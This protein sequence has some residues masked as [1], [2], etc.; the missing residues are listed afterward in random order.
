MPC[1]VQRGRGDVHDK[2]RNV[3]GTLHP[4]LKMNPENRPFKTESEVG[5]VVKS[6]LHDLRQ[7]VYCEVETGCGRIDIVSVGGGVITAVELKVRL[8]LDVLGQAI[9]RSR[10]VHRSVAAFPMPKQAYY[11]RLILSAVSESTGI[12]I[13]IVKRNVVDELHAP[14][15]YRKPC[16]RYIRAALRDEQ[17][18]QLAGVSKGYWSPFQQTR[19]ALVSFVRA[20]PGCTLKSAMKAVDHH[21]ASHSTA[22][23]SM[24]KWVRTGVI[25]EV[26][27]REDGGLYLVESEGL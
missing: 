10:Y 12:G 20:N 26:E 17:K 7:D 1:C 4:R 21:Y 6:Y 11:K 13:W 16:D 15:L 27:R 5:E 25:K 8:S 2:L 9:D 18:Q 24:S 19:A 22:Y 23:N 14:R 3:V